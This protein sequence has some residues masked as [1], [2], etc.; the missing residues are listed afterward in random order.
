V[1]DDALKLFAIERSKQALGDGD[2]GALGVPAGRKRIGISIRH[3][4]QFWRRQTRSDGHLLDNIAQLRELEAKLR[5]RRRE[6]CVDRNR[7]C[8]L[9]HRAIS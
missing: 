7:L 9:Q 1:R 3:D 8:R 6:R 5:V 2:G 4:E